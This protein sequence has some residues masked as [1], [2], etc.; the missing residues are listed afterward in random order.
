MLQERY[1]SYD[2]GIGKKIED[3]STSFEE[4][5][6]LSSLNKDNGILFKT[7]KFVIVS[8]QKYIVAN[9]FPTNCS[10]QQE[11]YEVLLNNAL[12]Y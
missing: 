3:G 6:V 5:E 8:L 1:A 4:L 12:K 10:G 7:L 2:S 9:G 11:K